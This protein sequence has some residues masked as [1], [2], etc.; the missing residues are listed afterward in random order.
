MRRHQLVSE[1]HYITVS[2]VCVLE[3]THIQQYLQLVCLHTCDVINWWTIITR[4]EWHVCVLVLPLLTVSCVY[5]LSV[6]FKHM[7]RHHLVSETQGVTRVYVSS[8]SAVFTVCLHPREDSDRCRLL[9]WLLSYLYS[10][11]HITG[12]VRPPVIMIGSTRC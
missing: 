4:S 3:F 11:N 8:C 7:W 6:L 2:H 1:S 5:N 12:C 9:R 10:T